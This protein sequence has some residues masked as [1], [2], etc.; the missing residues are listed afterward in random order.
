[1]SAFNILKKDFYNYCQRVVYNGPPQTI[2][3]DYKGRV[4]DEYSLIRAIE[5][6]D[7]SI[8]TSQIENPSEN[9][10]IA[11]IKKGFGFWD[12]NKSKNPSKKI[13]YAYFMYDKLPKEN[14]FAENYKLFTESEIIDILNKKPF[15]INHIENQL[16]KYCI[17]SINKNPNSIRYIKEQNLEYCKLAIKVLNTSKAYYYENDI[18]LYLKFYDQELVNMILENPIILEYSYCIPNQYLNPSM[19]RKLILTKPKLVNNFSDY[20]DQSLCNDLFNLSL[21]NISFIP[22]KYYTDI[23]ID[24]VS[25]STRYHLYKFISPHPSRYQQIFDLNP[26][27]IKYIPYEYQTLDMHCEAVKKDSDNLRFCEPIT[28][29]LF[30]IIFDSKKGTPKTDRFNFIRYYPED[31]LIKII[32]LRPDLLRVLHTSLQTHNII[33]TAITTDG[34]SYQFVGNKTDDYERISRKYPPKPRRTIFHNPRNTLVFKS[35][36]TFVFC[37]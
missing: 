9:V 35:D 5:F 10:I 2:T 3:E 23:M 15:Y 8:I 25:Q 12:I 18:L 24:T 1:M 33:L 13:L 37:S 19:I 6:C 27:N 34:S 4:Y 16:D 14:V 17:I 29:H 7:Y 32:R 21:D 26:S 28:H 30:N 22:K 31:I 20:I 36:S 11:L